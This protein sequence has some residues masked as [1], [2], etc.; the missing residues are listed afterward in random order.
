MVTGEESHSTFPSPGLR[1]QDN[2]HHPQVR[3]RARRTTKKICA[4]PQLV[5]RSSLEIR[6]CK[7]TACQTYYFFYN[8]LVFHEKYPMVLTSLVRM[9]LV[10]RELRLLIYRQYASSRL[11]L[12]WSRAVNFTYKTLPGTAFSKGMGARILR[13]LSWANLAF[14]ECL[15]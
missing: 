15:L 11:F 6:T 5:C 2:S 14:C 4:R 9:N 7:L 1:A 8:N 13:E 3:P 10:S 12:Q